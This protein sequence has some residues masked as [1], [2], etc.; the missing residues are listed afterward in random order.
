MKKIISFAL[1]GNNF[2]YVGGA[3]QNIELA[4]IYFPDWI[5]RFY[6]GKSTEEKFIQ[7]ISSFDN[8]EIIR[9]DEDGDWT[10]MFWR[11]KA[12]C[13]PEVSIMLSRDT[14]S[15]L[16]K[17][18]YE[19]VLEFEKSDKLFH[20]IRD[21]QN[22]G[23]PILGGMWGAKKGIIDNIDKLINKFTKG[24][25]WQVDQN[26]LT[27]YIYPIVKDDSLVHD[28]FFEKKP[29][30]KSA[31]ERNKYFFIGQAY[32][33]DGRILDNKSESY[34]KYIEDVDSFKITNYEDIF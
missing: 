1:W 18:E 19:A 10:G 13:D 30:P 33:G 25:F 6:I 27:Q 11:F 12:I 21:H 9:M 28:E 22:H 32:D 7:K 31:G 3:L 34:C 23:I 29:L 5:C 14:D 26:F 8:V 2:R 16:G 20:I 17:R 15:R 24:D 4:K